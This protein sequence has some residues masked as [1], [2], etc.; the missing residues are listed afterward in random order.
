MQFACCLGRS[1]RLKTT[2]GAK[3]SGRGVKQDR[4]HD[5]DLPAGQTRQTGCPSR[6][7]GIPGWPYRPANIPKRTSASDSSSVACC[8]WQS[9]P[10]GSLR[11]TIRR[12]SGRAAVS[13]H[14][15]RPLS[16]SAHCVLFVVVR[17]RK[18]GITPTVATGWG[19]FNSNSNP[20]ATGSDASGRGLKRPAPIT[21]SRVL[22]YICIK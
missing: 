22:F 14:H 18:A 10:T 8:R 11:L 16:A 21:L 6:R 15:A 4:P 7:A 1:C 12:R 3:V 9:A 5:R 13:E 20:Y 19:F 2:L 17:R